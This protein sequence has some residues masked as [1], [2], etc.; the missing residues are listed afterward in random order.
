MSTA[1]GKGQPPQ[2]ALPTE[3]RAAYRS[4]VLT[5][6]DALQVG[7]R[8]PCLANPD[9]WTA[10]ALDPAQ[11]ATAE[12]LCA[13]CPALVQCGAYATAAPER[14]G[15]WGGR[16]RG[17]RRSPGRPPSVAASPGPGEASTTATPTEAPAPP[18]DPSHPLASTSR[19]K[20]SPAL[21]QYLQVLRDDEGRTFGEMVDE[22][23]TAGVPTV[24][25]KGRWTEAKVRSILKYAA[26]RGAS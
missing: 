5:L 7:E 20:A 23:Q 25:H 19:R 4:L 17:P 1:R 13:G 22:L 21:V 6:G 18:P 11:V 8:V 24:S 3:A 12:R 2:L 26:E 14:W 10:D 15:V 16:W 9:G